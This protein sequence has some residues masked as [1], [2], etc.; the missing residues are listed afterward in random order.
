MNQLLLGASGPFI[1][2]TIIYFKSKYRA[3]V[4]ML[5]V[6]PL[7]MALSMLW[8]I[9]PDI[10]RLLGMQDLYYRM[11]KDPRC[12]IFYWHYSIDL[13]ETDSIIYLTVFVAMMIL[14][15]FVAWRELYM[16]EKES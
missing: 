8:A 3:S 5:I 4:R 6:T 10:P 15:L 2:G 7:F 13:I 11:A 14:I 16:V 12:N 9:I 1:I